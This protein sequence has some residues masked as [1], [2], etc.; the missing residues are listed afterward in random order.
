MCVYARTSRS[1]AREKAVVAFAG[2]CAASVRSMMRASPELSH[3]PAMQQ[4]AAHPSQLRTTVTAPMLHGRH[5]D[6][7]R[8]R[9]HLGTPRATPCFGPPR[10]GPRRTQASSTARRQ[11]QADSHPAPGTA[12]G[13]RQ[14]TAG[15]V[16]IQ[17]V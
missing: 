8:P 5:A 16:I 17:C 9:T 3:A 10:P 15:H 14:V 11:G 7:L 13:V 4:S 12:P 2:A 1:G 6:I